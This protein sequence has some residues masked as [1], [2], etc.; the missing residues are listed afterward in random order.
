[1]EM[2]TMSKVRHAIIR[3][4]RSDALIGRAVKSEPGDTADPMALDAPRFVE[5]TEMADA[6]EPSVPPPSK[7]SEKETKLPQQR[8]DSKKRKI[9]H[10]RDFKPP[11]QADRERAEWERHEED[12]HALVEELGAVGVAERSVGPAP[13]GTDG[14]PASAIAT[15]STTTTSRPLTVPLPTY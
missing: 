12:M 8:R 7:P 4:L 13:A 14:E 5:D 1:M 3:E 11:I 15:V 10:S 6:P 9:P 2:M